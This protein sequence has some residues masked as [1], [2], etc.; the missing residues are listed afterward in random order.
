LT[1]IVSLLFDGAA[2]R[3]AVDDESNGG[4]S[5]PASVRPRARRRNDRARPPVRRRV[6]VR[7]TRAVTRA[8]T[9]ALC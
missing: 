7:P 8:R 6:S 3:D 5:A 9:D 2:L 4:A 1:G